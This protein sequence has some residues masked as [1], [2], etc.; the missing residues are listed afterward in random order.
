MVMPLTALVMDMSGECKAC[1]TPRTA[2]EPTH[3]DRA[4]VAIEPA[5]GAW[6]CCA[7][8]VAAG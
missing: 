8:M 3:T 5:S 4:S 2:C 6:S 7:Q 1:D